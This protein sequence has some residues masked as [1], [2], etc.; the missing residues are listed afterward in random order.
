MF[1]KRTQVK[2]QDIK[3]VTLERDMIGDILNPEFD[4]YYF[5]KIDEYP[6]DIRTKEFIKGVIGREEY[7]CPQLSKDL[8]QTFIQHLFKYV[9]LTLCLTLS[10]FSFIHFSDMLTGFINPEFSAI[11]TIIDVAKGLK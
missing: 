4:T 1:Y 9:H 8:E 6:G 3:Y 11:M 10:Y 7:S 5:K 2:Q